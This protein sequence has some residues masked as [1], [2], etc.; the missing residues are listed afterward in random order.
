MIVF[1]HNLQNIIHSIDF[2]YV[3]NSFAITLEGTQA[4]AVIMDHISR[5]KRGF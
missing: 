5:D 3:H 1:T 4:E 2:Y